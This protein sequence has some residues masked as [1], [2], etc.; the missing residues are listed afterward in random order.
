MPGEQ[1]YDAARG[2]L[3]LIE[4]PPPERIRPSIARHTPTTLQWR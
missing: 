4:N 1:L 3:A 2:A